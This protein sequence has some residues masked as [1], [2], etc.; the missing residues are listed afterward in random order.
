MGENEKRVAVTKR[1][2]DHTIKTKEELFE[3]YKQHMRQALHHQQ[4]AYFCMAA[5]LSE[6]IGDEQ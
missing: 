1:E 6:I 2:D 3:E 4:E 5:L